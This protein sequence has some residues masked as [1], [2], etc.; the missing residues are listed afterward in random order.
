MSSA[1]KKSSNLIDSQRALNLSGILVNAMVGGLG[2]YSVS[3]TPLFTAAV[4][5]AV[6]QLALFVHCTQF[7]TGSDSRL[8]FWLQ[9]L[10][11]GT[12]F[13][14]VPSDFI[15]ILTVVW[16][17]QSVELYG[18]KRTVWHFVGTAI[19]FTVAQLVYFGM[20]NM[21]DYFI[22]IGLYSLLNMFAISVV[23]KF[24]GERE[25]K[26]HMAEL[27]RD[28]MATRDLLSQSSAQSERLRISRDLHDILGHHMT[29]LILN[30]EVA[31][32]QVE[33]E[34]KEKVEQSLALAKL[35]LSDLRSTVGELRDEGSINLEESIN[36]LVSGIPD[37]AIDVDFST[38]AKIDDVELAETF[39]RCTQEA[40]TN[41]LRH[42]NANHC[43]IEMNRDDSCYTLSVSDNGNVAGDI[44]PGNGLKGMQ[45]RV[46]AM[47][48]ELAWRQN[49][50]GFQLIVSLG[51]PQLS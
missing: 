51:A 18:A 12:L 33:G 11:I 27:N 5:L 40:V 21:L 34:P 36:A 23:Q 17:V 31:K 50:K 45:E 41:V 38:A 24:V 2:A 35:L 32:H 4:V 19:V 43:R 26:E 7:A 30:L 29:A 44:Q 8:S 37:F 1:I 48:G 13:F 3:G 20:T 9:A 6:A 42:S 46:N 49:E 16:L 39:L 47:G 28:L 15:Y 22:S 10:C 25:Q 14:V